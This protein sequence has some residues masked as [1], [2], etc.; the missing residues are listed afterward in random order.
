MARTAGESS[1]CGGVIVAIVMR[2]RCVSARLAVGRGPE[3]DGEGVGQEMARDTSLESE[4]V[5]QM[6][7]DGGSVG[8]EPEG[9]SGSVGGACP[10]AAGVSLLDG[11]SGACPFAAGV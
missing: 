5:Q 3:G 2:S 9:D 1:D 8:R 4:G 10:F 7:G 11:F 6:V